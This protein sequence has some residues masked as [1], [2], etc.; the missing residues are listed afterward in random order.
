[1][2]V[3]ED[4]S[5]WLVSIDSNGMINIGTTLRNTF[6]INGKKYADQAYKYLPEGYLNTFYEGFYMMYKNKIYYLLLTRE[7]LKAG[8]PN[9]IADDNVDIV[10]VQVNSQLICDGQTLQ[11]RNV[12][13]IVNMWKFIHLLK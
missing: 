2:S 1:M 11:C 10:I 4:I 9:V 3:T 8:L 12:Y 13:S 6:P 5:P 7:G